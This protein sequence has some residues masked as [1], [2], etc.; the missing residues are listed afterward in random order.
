MRDYYYDLVEP[1]TLF[2]DKFRIPTLSSI[3]LVSFI[4]TKIFGSDYYNAMIPSS[5]QTIAWMAKPPFLTALLQWK[6][7]GF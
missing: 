1:N 7:L 6:N 5:N 3:L 4:V 2:L